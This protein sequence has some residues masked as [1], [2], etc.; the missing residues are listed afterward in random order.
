MDD[1]KT[2]WDKIK[3]IFISA[4]FFSVVFIAFKSSSMPPKIA[5]VVMIPIALLA[6]LSD[7]RSGRLYEGA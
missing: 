5:T 2:A 1:I 6:F 4:L 3:H 7:R